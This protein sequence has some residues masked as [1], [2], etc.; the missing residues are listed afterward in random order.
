MEETIKGIVLGYAVLNKQLILFTHDVNNIDYIYKVL[1]DENTGAYSYSILLQGNLNFS[2]DSRFETLSIYENESIQKIYWVD[3]VNQPR[4]INIADSY[5]SSAEGVN[6][7]NFTPL[8]NLNE[9]VFIQNNQ[10]AGGQ[11]PAGTVQY[12]F[13]YYNK[14]G[15]ESNLFYLS[16]LFYISYS[17]R[18][19]AANSVLNNVFEIKITNVDT[20]F[21]YI[22]IY[23]ILRTNENGTPTIKQVEDIQISKDINEYYYV[24]NNMNGSIVDASTLLYV[25]GM[26]IIPNTIE[27]K[28][29]VLFLGNYTF[30]QTPISVELKNSIKNGAVKRPGIEKS[31]RTDS[32][33]GRY[34]Y[35]NQLKYSYDQ[36]SC[37]KYLEWYRFGVQFQDVYGSWS[38]VVWL[39][40]HQHLDKPTLTSP[41]NTSTLT[42][43][44]S[45]PTF[46]IDTGSISSLQGSGWVKM[47]P[48]VVYPKESERSIVAQGIVCPTVYNVE[49][50]ATNSPF[51]QSSWFARPNIPFDI[52]YTLQGSGIGNLPLT[53]DIITNEPYSQAFIY[54]DDIPGNGWSMQRQTP[55]KLAKWC[56][57]RHDCPIPDN[58][59]ENSEIQSIKS[60]PS[61]FVGSGSNDDFVQ[62]N[63]EYY[64]VDQSVVTFHSPELEL[65]SRSSSVDL[66]KYKFR[67]VGASYLTGTATNHAINTD[68]ISMS[69]YYN[70]VILNDYANK[71]DF[72]KFGEYTGNASIDNSSYFGFR[73][74]L[75]NPL[76]LD[77][78]LD[79]GQSLVGSNRWRT[80]DLGSFVVY[81]WNRA[82]SLNNQDNI[83]GDIDHT[84][85]IADAN[86]ITFPV[87]T[88]ELKDKQLLNLRFSCFN[89]YFNSDS[90]WSENGVTHNGVSDIQLFN[91]TNQEG[92]TLKAPRNSNLNDFIY[93]GNI[94][95]IISPTNG[96]S[97]IGRDY[98]ANKYSTANKGKYNV[99]YGERRSESTF[100]TDT[101]TVADTW[102]KADYEWSDED[103][104]TVPNFLTDPVRL[105]YKS[106][107]HAVIVLNYGSNRRQ[108]ILPTHRHSTQ[109]IDFNDSYI[110]FRAS[111]DQKQKGINQFCFQRTGT[112]HFWEKDSSIYTGSYG[113]P[114]KVGFWGEEDPY[115]DYRGGFVRSPYRWLNI[116][117]SGNY[118]YWYNPDTGAL[119]SLNG[120]TWSRDITNDNKITIEYEDEY[121]ITRYLNNTSAGA[122]FP[123]NSLTQDSLLLN[124]DFGYFWIGEIYNDNI[125]NRFGGSSESALSQNEWIIAGN[126]VDISDGTLVYTRGDT[127]IQRY[128][129]LKTYT[130]DPEG[131]NSI[132]DIVSFFCETH[133]NIDGRY[134]RN[135]G[136]SKNLLLTPELMNLLNPAYNQ[137]DNLFIYHV[138]DSSRFSLNK[139]SNSITWSKTKIFGEEIDSW[140][141]I[142]IVDN[143]DLDGEKGPLRSIKRFNNEL[144]SFQ[145]EGIANILY[146]TRTQI[147]TTEFSNIIIGN[148]GKVDGKV[149]ISQ[150]GTSNA[151]S[152]KVTPLGI[153]FIDG[154]TNGIYLFNGESLRCISDE[155][156][157]R[158]WI[159]TNVNNEEWTPVGF[160]NFVTHYDES[161]DDVYFTNREYC[162]N[163]SEYL[164]GFSSFLSYENTPHMFTWDGLFYS[165]L[166]DQQQNS[167]LYLNHEGDHNMFYKNIFN[168]VDPIYQP[169]SV[170]VV[171][172]EDPVLDKLF[173]N[174]DFKGDFFDVPSGN[175]QPLQTYDTLNVQTEYQGNTSSLID[176][177][178]HKSTLKKK[179]NRWRADIP[180]D[181]TNIRQRIRNNWA[182]IKLSKETP[183]TY[184]SELHD[185]LV[186][187]YI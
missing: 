108:T 143:L 78:F 75:S 178:D 140:T 158:D 1:R 87:V 11:F 55:L 96:D 95:R 150:I 164:N 133:I 65:A 28:D 148:S 52:N 3:G 43:F 175:Y 90:L 122:F 71:P 62:N 110:T 92:I 45:S 46:S 116:L 27:E 25:G 169:Y 79:K 81:P 113:N 85:A 112:K 40:D 97:S 111:I 146:N 166:F 177:I 39:G 165:I 36:I 124:H 181:K 22:R 163:F 9:I 54:R 37:F 137:T 86:E 17:D 145:D 102:Y 12:A 186:Y 14:N 147:P 131:T 34:P 179:F 33:S 129:H 5:I 84:L 106:T 80:I 51:A 61:V 138:I 134:D 121:G 74:E 120:S 174:V 82:Y 157:F 183:N 76:W 63:K 58:R 170:S 107:P 44:V 103:N 187:Y 98:I 159:S 144:F 70:S 115:E 35:N 172:N 114:I 99:V 7:V 168:V 162:L 23:S 153:Y 73:G 20:S 141:K 136:N 47:R 139:F 125:L 64:Y 128:D 8:M 16:D 167:R 184:M 142:N 26:S 32:S 118:R 91:S 182:L 94:D 56:E 156:G 38:D 18:G 185:L 126:A 2:L 4:F 24:D 93:Y 155:F 21:D 173:T 29:N 101:I 41:L 83:Y 149:Y 72:S 109:S 127:Y 88:A 50:R 89:E 160:K 60:P 171:A 10:S 119:K 152:I 77:R 161:S 117:P 130:S 53:R 6:K 100:N 135:R 154:F 132:T 19:G 67:I 49:D 15:T 30:S 48:V 31:I 57:F 105:Q 69:E 66:S 104:K 180:R 59:M 151:G 13:S 176:N 42:T 123:E 68:T